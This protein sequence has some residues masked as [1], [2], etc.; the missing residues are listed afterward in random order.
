M[1]EIAMRLRCA[2]LSAISILGFLLAWAAQTAHAMSVSPTHIELKSSGA[3]NRA[4]VVVRNDSSAPL[5]V[6]AIV[7]RLQLDESGKQHKTRD[8]ASFL[9]FPP[10]TI[11]P[12]G[13]SQVFRITWVG[14][15][16]LE[17]SQSFLLTLAQIPVQMKEPQNRVQVVMAFGVVINVAPPKGEP[18]LQVVGSGITTTANGRRNPVITVQN[19]SRVHALLPRAT[20]RLTSAG[21]SQTLTPA[22]LDQ[23]VGIGLVQPGKRRRFVLPIS[24]PASVQE[25]RASLELQATRR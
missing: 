14:E 19:P 16:L 17:Q 15:P 1:K 5:P 20:I 7:D 13:A 4:Q 18:E 3:A 22:A 8:E 23:K 24:V 25:V 9:V 6:E 21:W 10:Q 12:P 2:R 11:V